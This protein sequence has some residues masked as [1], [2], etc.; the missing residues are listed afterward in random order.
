MT[1]PHDER[2]SVQAS[3][4]SSVP[5]SVPTSVPTSDPASDPAS[6]PGRRLVPWLVPLLLAAATLI[7]V[8][9]RP[10]PAP[11][12]TRT[13]SFPPASATAVAI[14]GD[15][16]PGTPI[17]G[18]IVDGVE[19]PGVEGQDAEAILVHLHRD[20]IRLA[21]TVAPRGALNYNPPTQTAAYDLFFGHLQPDD[22]VLDA[23]DSAPLLKAFEAIV[24]ANE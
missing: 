2:T 21:I 1:D 3:E 11:A 13:P 5:A 18:F 15:L 12:P 20:E 4:P 24:I 10:E 14:L 17:A 8:L 7:Y 6:D 9:L 23:E 16:Q 19:G 22:A